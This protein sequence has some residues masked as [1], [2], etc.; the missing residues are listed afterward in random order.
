MASLTTKQITN[1]SGFP[2]AGELIEITGAHLLDAPDRAIQ[3]KLF[4]HA[5]DSGKLTDPDA[6]WELSL[7]ELRGCLSKHEG[8]DRVRASLAKLRRVEVVV[9]YTTPKTGEPRT[10]ITNLLDF[11]DTSDGDGASATVQYGLPKKLR[12]VLARSNRWGRVKCEITYA[13]T[14]KYAMALYELICLRANL[15]RC[16]ETIPLDRFRELLGVPPGAYAEG[17]DFRLKVLDPAMLEVNGL[18]DMGVQIEAV[19]RHARA[20]VTAVT[21]AWWRKDGDEHQAAMR[22]LS[23]SKLGRMARLKG[24]VETVS[25]ARLSLPLA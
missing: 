2:K 11:I 6:E 14:S 7:A 12:A 15:E 24:V 5:H 20:P 10:L 17:K 1:F 22:E 23:R 4:Q 25:P 21:L 16:I 8:N 13:M 18:S 19:R 9:H 3:N